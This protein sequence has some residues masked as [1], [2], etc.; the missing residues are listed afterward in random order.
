MNNNNNKYTFWYSSCCFLS[1]SIWFSF[2]FNIF[3]NLIHSFDLLSVA[4][5]I[6]LNSVNGLSDF[7]IVKGILYKITGGLATNFLNLSS[8]FCF[9]LIFFWNSCWYWIPRFSVIRLKGTGWTSGIGMGI[10]WFTAFFF[11][12][13]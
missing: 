6:S 2:S 1:F 10:L 5:V 9:F 13:Y 11:Y 4:N 7:V 3:L 8:S 12:L